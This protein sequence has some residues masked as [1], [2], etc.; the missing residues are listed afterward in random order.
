MGWRGFIRS[1]AASSRR[2]DATRRRE[3]NA[4]VRVERARYR[5][6]RQNLAAAIRADAIQHARAEVEEYEARLAALKGVHVPPAESIHWQAFLEVPPPPPPPPVTTAADAARAELANYQPSLG[7][8][9]LGKT[10]AERSHL[11][12]MVA[13]GQKTDAH[14]SAQLASQYAVM[15]EQWEWQRRLAHGVIGG[16]PEAYRVALEWTSTFEELEELDAWVQL[17]RILPGAIEVDLHVNDESVVPTESKALTAGGKLTSKKLS[18]SARYDIH[19]DFVCGSALRLA[20]D[21]TAAL[22]VHGV[23]VHVV[24]ELLNRATGNLESEAILTAWMPRTTLEHLNFARVDASDSMK[25][26]LHR[27]DWNK[28]RGFVAVEPLT[29]EAAANPAAV[30]QMAAKRGR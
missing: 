17:H 21:V 26:F 30:P 13:V 28:S 9:I 15:V 27:M 25:N 2:A 10:A 6:A 24:G 19:Q 23:L 11:E 18:A 7:A 16:D 14:R 8:R 12:D 20:R 1:V 5:Q 22:P 29:L 3:H 4:A